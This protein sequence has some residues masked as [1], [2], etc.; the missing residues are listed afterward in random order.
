MQARGFAMRKRSRHEVTL[1]ACVHSPE[2]GAIRELELCL[3]KAAYESWF[4]D[5]LWQLSKLK[6]GGTVKHSDLTIRLF[7]DANNAG[8]RRRYVMKRG[9]A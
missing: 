4:V 8:A 6:P 1:E 5:F 3:R 7:M 2:A 9:V